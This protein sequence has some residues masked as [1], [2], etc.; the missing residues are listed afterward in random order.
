MVKYVE[1]KVV[2]V[3][4]YIASNACTEHGVQLRVCKY[5]CSEVYFHWENKQKSKL[6]RIVFNARAREPT[7]NATT[8]TIHLIALSTGCAKSVFALSR[9]VITGG[10]RILLYCIGTTSISYVITTYR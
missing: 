10:V 1:T 9:E 5:V 3:V 7:I 4:L 6:D 8:T 2:A